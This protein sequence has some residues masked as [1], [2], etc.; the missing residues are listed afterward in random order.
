MIRDATADD[1]DALVALGQ[2]MHDESRFSVLEYSPQKVRALLSSLI[3]SQY[4]KVVERGG[5]VVGGFAGVVLPHWSSQDLVGYDL[6]LFMS[7]DNR[8]GGTAAYLLNGFRK[9]ALSRGAK[10]VTI[11][12]STGV[13]VE[14]TRELYDRLQFRTVGYICE[15]VQDVSRT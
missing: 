4:M 15:G 13:E 3:G 14:K 1:L 10:M 9:W 2:A 7:R 8:G 5:S 11:G 6:G 12:I